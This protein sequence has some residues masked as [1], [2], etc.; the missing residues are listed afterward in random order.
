M[1]VVVG[2]GVKTVVELEQRLI[3]ISA[4]LLAISKKMRFLG[5]YTRYTH[6]LNLYIETNIY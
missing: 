1:M 5:T 4:E 2:A 6:H 3:A